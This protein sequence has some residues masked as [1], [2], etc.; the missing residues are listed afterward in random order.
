MDW[1]RTIFLAHAKEDKIIIRKLYNELKQ[2]NLNPWLDEFSI[3]PGKKWKEEIENAIKKSRFFVACI[4]KFSVKKAGYVQNEL[5]L[6][7]QEFE[8]RPPNNLYFIP[9]LLDDL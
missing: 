2:E 8:S 5:R 4:S 7:L 9:V 3:E 6:A 1:N